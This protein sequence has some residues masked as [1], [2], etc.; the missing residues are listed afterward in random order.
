MAAR[1]G[2]YAREGRGVEDVEGGE[3]CDGRGGEGY[4]GGGEEEEVGQS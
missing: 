2:D 3:G 1:R 4:S